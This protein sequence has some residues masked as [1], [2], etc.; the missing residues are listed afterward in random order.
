MRAAAGRMTD[1]GADRVGQALR[2]AA[3]AALAVGSALAGTAIV[4]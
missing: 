2:T 3:M 1:P 4:R